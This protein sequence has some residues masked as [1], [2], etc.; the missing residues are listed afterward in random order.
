MRAEKG[1]EVRVVAGQL[2]C[3]LRGRAVFE[4]VEGAADGDDVRVAEGGRVNERSCVVEEVVPD[5]GGCE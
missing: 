3:E 2:A 4:E 5:E 1:E